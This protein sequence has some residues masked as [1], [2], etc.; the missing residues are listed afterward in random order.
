MTEKIPGNKRREQ[1]NQTLE[2]IRNAVDKLTA[3][4]GFEAMTIREICSEAGIQAGG[5]YHHFASKDDL[6]YD[7]YTRTNHHFAQLY[8]EQLAEMEPVEGLQLFC[9]RYLGYTQSRVFRVMVQYNRTILLHSREWEAR[10]P[11]QALLILCALMERGQVVGSI[12][13]DYTA[14]QLGEMLWSILTGVVR[15]YCISDGS[16]FATS[17]SEELICEWI[18]EQ[19]PR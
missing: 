7:R 19:C 5:F 2:K 14:R 18:A 16:Y 17:R 12:R 9:R 6:L 3:E 4:K 8:Q 13:T 10:E 1:Y 15:S 11:N